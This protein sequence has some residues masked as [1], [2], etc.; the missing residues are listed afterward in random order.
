MSLGQ[1][2]KKRDWANLWQQGLLYEQVTGLAAAQ[3]ILMLICS[4]CSSLQARTRVFC[5]G[6]S[7]HFQII[8]AI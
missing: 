5:A 3:T 1:I 6:C 8:S 4:P 2:R 7:V